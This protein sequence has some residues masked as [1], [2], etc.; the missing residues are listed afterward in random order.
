MSSPVS[1]N[2]F[3][4]NIILLPLQSS[5]CRDLPAMFCCIIYQQYEFPLKTKRLG[6]GSQW[7]LELDSQVYG[8]WS[9]EDGAMARS[10]MWLVGDYNM[11]DKTSVIL[12]NPNPGSV[13]VL[14]I[15]LTSDQP[16]ESNTLCDSRAE[17]RSSAR[18]TP[19]ILTA[20]NEYSIF[21]NRTYI[22]L[23]LCSTHIT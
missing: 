12:M 1:Y 19:D 11:V 9:R 5:C 21:K 2:N 18:K 23:D 20:N 14:I 16:P 15:T 4:L 13:P 6:M 22:L 3:L 17:T 7:E 8:M 10:A